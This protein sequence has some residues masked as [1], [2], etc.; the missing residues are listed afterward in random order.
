MVNLGSAIAY[1]DL[2]NSGFNSALTDSLRRLNAFT[3][4]S[5]SAGDKFNAL[6]GA[7]TSAGKSLTVG[8]T[9]PLLGLGTASIK[10]A[11]DF[12]AAMSKVEAISGANAEEMELLTQK[13]KRMGETTKFSATESAEALQYMAM[14]GWKTED[15]LNGIEGIMNLAAADGLDLATTSD[16][17]T[18][19]LTAFGLTAKDSGHFADVLAVAASNS[20]TNVAMLGESFKYAA[21]TAGALNYSVEDIALALGL[22]ANSG[23]KS[24]QA[25]TALRASMSRL[26]KPTEMMVNKMQE[27]G[28]A[29]QNT[30]VVV[31]KGA[32]QKAEKDITKQTDKLKK[33]ESQLADKTLNVEKAQ[34]K[35]NDA[36]TKYGENSSQ[37]QKA[38]IDLEKAQDKV[39][40]AADKVAQQQEMLNKSNQNLIE[41]Q[42]GVIEETGVQTLVLTDASGKIRPFKEVL[43]ILRDSFKGLSEAE[44]ANAAATLFGQEAM[45]GMLA[46]INASDEDYEKLAA[47]ISEADGTAEDMASVMLDNLS[48][49]ITILKSGVEGLAI[50]FGEILI[51]KVRAGVEF[52]TNIVSS[53]NALDEQTKESIVQ[54][55]LVA[56]AI[57]PLLLVLGSLFK[58]VG[59]GI[60]TISQ[61]VAV[62]KGAGTAIAGINAPVLAVIAAITAL[63]GIIVYLWNTNEEFKKG[64][65]DAWDDIK[66]SI[67]NAIETLKP[68]LL[69][70]K[71]AFGNLWDSVQPLVE[72]IGTVLVQA[73][74]LVAPLISA[75]ATVLSPILTI[76]ADILTLVADIIALI[77]SPLGGKNGMS[78]AVEQLKTDFLGMVDTIKGYY[79]E[80][81]TW[82][83]ENTEK[84]FDEVMEFLGIDY[85]F[86]DLIEDIKPG[87][88]AV[89]TKFNELKGKISEI[90]SKVKE[91]FQS[92]AVEA[93]KKVLE[94]LSP[95][96]EEFK[97]LMKEL[98]DDLTPFF[99]SLKEAFEPFIENIGDALIVLADAMGILIALL[100]GDEQEISKAVENFK[101]S[102]ETWKEGALEVFA[103]LGEGIKLALQNV[104]ESFKTWVGEKIQDI[105]DNIVQTFEDIKEQVVSFFTEKIPQAFEDFMAYLATTPERIGEGISE[106][107]LKV[108]ELKTKVD[109]LLEQLKEVVKE[110]VEVLKK[111]LTEW[112]TDFPNK[113]D[114]TMNEARAFVAVKLIVLKNDFK[115]WKKELFEFFDTL[116]EKF[117]EKATDMMTSF[118]E[119]F[120]TIGEDISKW[121]DTFTLSLLKGIGSV[122]SALSEVKNSDSSG[123]YSSGL[124][125]VPYDGYV[126]TLHEGERV[127]T[128]Q[129]NEESKD[130]ISM[131]QNIYAPTSVNRETLREDTLELLRLAG[132]Y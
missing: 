39:T 6:G 121:F 7:L 71:E 94:K 22:M 75:L 42:K 118:F 87:I 90:A 9:T 98:A 107:I 55:G 67:Q 76:L 80:F 62:V 85:S 23:V 1:L 33:A 27:L 64:I 48:G 132:V 53:L 34:V 13:A 124:D 66:K 126:A 114:K 46:I 44:Q 99:E 25:G 65:T 110:K 29:V 36:I 58:L 129:E 82:L 19:A 57:G 100:S 108:G 122:T 28:L 26:A 35:L 18:D 115:D 24:S 38:A 43:D 123:S 63:V 92:K 102:L 2:D 116:P 51:P 84:A 10:M 45:S 11:S 14:A 49:A 83:V 68:G 54:I 117:K 60:N 91:A 104:W 69:D 20:N 31:D 109:E 106:A 47:A 89:I 74:Q 81:T 77:L 101:G 131:V 130:R 95:L 15:M 73:L 52:L 50:S 103:I 125:Y 59:G 88:Q 128:K 37:A 78:E 79:D 41:S 97:N 12:E 17:V 8:V 61:L 72:L 111:E 93:F 119:G 40:A 112:F 32:I 30:S 96:M 113:F 86:K 4:S 21:S 127:L 3:D 56:A 120:K 5:L 70:L 105:K 16:I